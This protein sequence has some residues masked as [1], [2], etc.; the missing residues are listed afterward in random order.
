[1]KSVFIAVSALLMFAVVPAAAQDAATSGQLTI[2]SGISTGEITPTPEMWFYQQYKSE[3]Q[4]PKVAV[5]EKAEFRALQRQRRIAA[6]KW[7]GLS[8]QRPTNSVDPFNGDWSPRWTSGSFWYPNRWHGT[9]RP[10]IIVRS[11]ELE[12]RVR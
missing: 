3:Y 4:D 7:F 11:N 10:W 9:G 1:M 2:P 6:K 8:N 12:T 5:R